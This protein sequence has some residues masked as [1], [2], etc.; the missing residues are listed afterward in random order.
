M[1]K[2]TL[3]NAILGGPSVLYD[4]IAALDALNQYSVSTLVFFFLRPQGPRIMKY[5]T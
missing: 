4:K 5:I 3:A 2:K 1:K